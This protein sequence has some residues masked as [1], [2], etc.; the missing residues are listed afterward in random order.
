M[1]L[2]YI[3]FYLISPSD[4]HLV[5][6]PKTF[7]F[8]WTIWHLLFGTSVET[9]T[10]I[11]QPVANKESPAPQP[12]QL[13]PPFGFPLTA[14]LWQVDSSSIHQSGHAKCLPTARGLACPLSPISTWGHG[15]PWLVAHATP[16]LQLSASR[17]SYSI[18]A[19]R[20]VTP[21]RL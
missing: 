11:K 12:C 3:K 14:P 19:H 20:T 15:C 16:T 4:S 6:V 21:N 1:F 7:S 13:T 8:G 2:F 10:G 17:C 5:W 18:L 9:P